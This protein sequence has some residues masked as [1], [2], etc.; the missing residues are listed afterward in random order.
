MRLRAARMRLTDI[1][2]NLRYTVLGS[3]DNAVLWKLRLSAAAV[4][5][6]TTDFTATEPIACSKS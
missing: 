1:Q 2:R 3:W 5:R 4:L 6:V